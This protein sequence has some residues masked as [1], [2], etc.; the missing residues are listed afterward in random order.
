MSANNFQCCPR[1]FGPRATLENIGCS[2]PLDKVSLLHPISFVV[3]PIHIQTASFHKSPQDC[4]NQVT[5][6]IYAADISRELESADHSDQCRLLTLSCLIPLALFSLLCCLQSIAKACQI[7][8]NIF[9]EFPL[10]SFISWPSCSLLAVATI[11]C[12]CI[13]HSCWSIPKLLLQL[14]V[15]CI[16]CSSCT[17]YSYLLL[18]AF[19][20]SKTVSFLIVIFSMVPVL[21]PALLLCCWSVPNQM[22]FLPTHATHPIAL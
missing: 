15:G 20:F 4:P 19:Q 22:P 12:Q 18:V 17:P 9:L 11:T 13:C 8:W 6:D 5:G 16:Y 7:C 3:P 1:A 10:V 2:S 21:H 14:T